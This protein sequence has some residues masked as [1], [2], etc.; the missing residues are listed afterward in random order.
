MKKRSSDLGFSETLLEI[1][2]FSM[3]LGSSIVMMTVSYGMMKSTE[4]IMHYSSMGMLFITV[5][6][7]FLYVYKKTLGEK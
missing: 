6:A 7:L 3:M 4:G 2:K 1:L 5:I